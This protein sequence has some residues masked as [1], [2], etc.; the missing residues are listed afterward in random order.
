MARVFGSALMNLGLICFLIRNENHTSIGIRAILTGNFLFHGID[1]VSTFIAAYSGVMNNL[2]W[3]FS[4][5]HFLLA[6]GFFYFLI[7]GKD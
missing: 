5:L 7:S 6:I 4:S 1:S 3:M 2:G